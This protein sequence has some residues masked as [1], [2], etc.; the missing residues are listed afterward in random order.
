MGIA[1]P[2]PAMRGREERLIRARIRVHSQLTTAYVLA[3]IAPD[4]A[5]KRARN[6]VIRMSAGELGV[7]PKRRS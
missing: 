7:T 1:I 3:G 6:E 2:R 4:E 5:S